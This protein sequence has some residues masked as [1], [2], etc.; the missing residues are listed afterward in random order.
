M[1]LLDA[2]QVLQQSFDSVK[3]ALRVTTA[4][5]FGPTAG[6]PEGSF[7]APVGTLYLQSDGDIGHVLWIKETGVGNTGWIRV[8]QSFGEISAND[9]STA[10]VLADKTKDYKVVAFDT[11]AIAS[12]DVVLDL[13]NSCI[14]VL[15]PGYYK[16]AFVHDFT[17]D[18]NKN[19]ETTA[20]CGVLGATT[21]RYTI[22]G[23]QKIAVGNLGSVCGTGFTQLNAND[24][25][26]L[27]CQCQSADGVTITTEHINLNILRIR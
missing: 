12:D 4:P 17:A 11:A 2:N 21:G 27:H 19:V 16:I 14:H 9:V 22:H 10:L 23:H 25:V 20:F 1:S 8:G 7:V 5:V 6:T 24:V 13:P 26:E 18:S 15:V 3:N